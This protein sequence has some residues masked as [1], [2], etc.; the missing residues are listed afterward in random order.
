MHI[1]CPLRDEQVIYGWRVLLLKLT[2]KGN[3]FKIFLL[4]ILLRSRSVSLHTVR[5]IHELV[6]FYEFHVALGTSYP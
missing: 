3:I 2:A 4:F 5:M 6:S 1:L